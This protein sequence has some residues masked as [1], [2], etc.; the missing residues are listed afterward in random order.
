LSQLRQDSEQ[1]R[2]RGA[3]VIAVAPGQPESVAKFT[4]QNPYP[5]PMLAD[6]DHSVFDAYDVISR[7]SSLGQRPA[8]FIIDRNQKVVFDSIG[9]QQW[10]I[11]GNTAVLDE[12]SRLAGSGTS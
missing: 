7:M 3:Q 2:D 8:V 6:A 12:V 1:F 5:F 11:P 10:Q 9:T 4:G